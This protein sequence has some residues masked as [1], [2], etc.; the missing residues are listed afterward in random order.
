MHMGRARIWGVELGVERPGGLA[1]YLSFLPLSLLFIL[2]SLAKLASSSSSIVAN[3]RRFRI[4][5]SILL[6]TDFGFWLFFF[7]GFV[8]DGVLMPGHAHA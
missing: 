5:G 2:R 1:C 7:N 4:D 3:S 6:L 8:K